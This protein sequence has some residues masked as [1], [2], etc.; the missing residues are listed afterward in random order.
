[1]H[2]SLGA[3]RLKDFYEFQFFMEFK[4]LITG[5]PTDYIKLQLIRR[6]LFQIQLNFNS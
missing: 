1:M 6:L 4:E 5:L 3:K 2:K